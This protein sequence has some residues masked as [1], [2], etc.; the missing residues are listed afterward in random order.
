MLTRSV[1]RR[2][3]ASPDVGSPN[4]RRTPNRAHLIGQPP[5]WLKKAL[6]VRKETNPI[7][8]FRRGCLSAG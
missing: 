1:R 3:G 5:G 8:G 2:G 6:T 4:R 7:P